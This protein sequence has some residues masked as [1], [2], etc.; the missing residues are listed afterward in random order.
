MH[1]V[2]VC[3]F[4]NETL[5][6]PIQRNGL[7]TTRPSGNLDKEMIS[8]RHTHNDPGGHR[9]HWVL[10]IY[11]LGA[12]LPLLLDVFLTKPYCHD[13]SLMFLLPAKEKAW[14]FSFF[15]HMNHSPKQRK[16]VGLAFFGN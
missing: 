10:S 9:L 15:N 1:R 7:F 4:C 2:I 14:G 8:F 3:H 6:K 12:S 16:V 13:S 5:Q 11:H